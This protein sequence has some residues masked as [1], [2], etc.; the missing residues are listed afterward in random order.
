MVRSTKL[1]FIG[2]TSRQIMS[3]VL[4]QLFGE[5]WYGCRDINAFPERQQ[6]VLKSYLNF[7]TRYRSLSKV[8]LEKLKNV[9]RLKHRPLIYVIA[10]IV[11]YHCVRQ[12]PKPRTTT[13]NTAILIFN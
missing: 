10:S 8:C 9:Q 13:W 3:L 4:K 12:K 1:N 11:K 5:F 2:S 7:S 6:H